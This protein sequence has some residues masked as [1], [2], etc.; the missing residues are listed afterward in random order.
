MKASFLWFLKSRA[1]LSLDFQSWTLSFLYHLWRNSAAR[2]GIT[3]RDT[4]GHH[5]GLCF[6]P[7]SGVNT[8][9]MSGQRPLCLSRETGYASAIAISLGNRK[10]FPRSMDEEIEAKGETSE[11]FQGGGRAKSCKVRAYS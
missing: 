7:V 6:L 5:S 9:P 2:G 10:Y 4:W 3:L 1:A 11:I 8:S